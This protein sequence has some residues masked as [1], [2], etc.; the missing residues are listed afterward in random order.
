MNLQNLTYTIN[1]LSPRQKA[2]ALAGIVG[3]SAVIGTIALSQRQPNRTIVNQLPSSS[4]SSPSSS[5]DPLTPN[6]TGNI[7]ATVTPDIVKPGTTTSRFNSSIVPSPGNSLNPGNSSV[8]PNNNLRLGTGSASSSNLNSYGTSSVGTNS[9]GAVD[10]NRINSAV[11]NLAPSTPPGQVSVPNTSSSTNIAPASPIIPRASSPIQDFS[12]PR[13]NTSPVTATPSEI[14]TTS[15]VDDPIPSSTQTSP[16][17]DSRTGTYTTTPS[18][19]N[20]NLRQSLRSPTNSV[21]NSQN[22]SDFYSNPN[23]SRPSGGSSG[24]TNNTSPVY[25][26]SNGT[27]SSNPIYSNPNGNINTNSIYGSPNGGSGSSTSPNGT[28]P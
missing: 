17:F 6:T 2:T 1:N 26:S 5:L 28:T 18:V 3:A 10:S 25:G 23:F 9:V 27:T 19:P 4:L 14:G 8:A 15:P 20:S 16:T 24:N 21:N 7:D 22:N 12:V 11:P 13:A